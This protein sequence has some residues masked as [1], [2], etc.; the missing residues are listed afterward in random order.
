MRMSTLVR[1]VIGA[2]ALALASASSACDS[3]AC[4]LVGCL[5]GLS[6][7]ISP[8]PTLPYRVEVHSGGG[9]SRYAWTCPTSG[10]CRGT[11]VFADYRPDRVFV[12]VIVGTDTSRHEIVGPI[13]YVETFPNGRACGGAC[14]AATVTVAR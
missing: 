4:T 1:L 3:G 13:R 11:A 9:T 8:P 7:A 5:S 10:G 6:I 2:G 14:Y 12:E